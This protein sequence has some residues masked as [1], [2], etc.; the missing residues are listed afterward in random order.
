MRIR[1]VRSGIAQYVGK[2]SYDGF[3]HHQRSRLAAGQHVVTDRHLF[4][5]HPFRGVVDDALVD[6]LVAPTGENQV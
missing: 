1:L 6:T 3:D 5:A 2:Q 4:D